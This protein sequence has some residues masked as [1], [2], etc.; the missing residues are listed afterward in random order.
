MKRKI[1][2]SLLIVLFIVTGCDN[3]PT[4]TETSKDSIYVVIDGEKFKL[5]SNNNLKDLHYK[6]NYVDFRTDALAKSRVMQ[7]SKKGEFIFEVRLIYEDTHSFEEVKELI[8]HE[9]STKKVNDI[10]YTYYNYK[11]SS[12]DDVHMYLYNYNNVTY[13]IMFIGN[14]ITNLEETFMNNVKFE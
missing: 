14:D 11:N 9:E 1:L 8:G 5:S 7:Y 13:T 12:N 4:P 10:D 6:E 3:K 2:L